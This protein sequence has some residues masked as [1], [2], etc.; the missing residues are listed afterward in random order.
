MSA[1]DT[2][3]RGYVVLVPDRGDEAFFTPKAFVEVYP[4]GPDRGAREALKVCPELIGTETFGLLFKPGGGQTHGDGVSFWR[5]V[6]PVPVEP[7]IERVS[8]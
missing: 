6:P 1:F 5:V 2:G 4:G 8:I 3:K 7:T